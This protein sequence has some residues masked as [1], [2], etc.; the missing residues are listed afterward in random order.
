MRDLWVAWRRALWQGQGL[1]EK[2]PVAQ[3]NSKWP[4]WRGDEGRSLFQSKVKERV[5]GS[6]DWLMQGWGGDMGVKISEF[7]VWCP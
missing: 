5:L 3:G 7:S 4:V 1:E 6:G 2:L